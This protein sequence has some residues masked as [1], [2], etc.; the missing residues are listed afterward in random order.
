MFSAITAYIETDIINLTDCICR[1]LNLV[2]SFSSQISLSNQVYISFLD[3]Q[4]ATKRDLCKFFML[5]HLMGLII[6]A[7]FKPTDCCIA[8]LQRISGCS[9]FALAGTTKKNKLPYVR[10]AYSHLG[11]NKSDGRKTA[12]EESGYKE[13]PKGTGRRLRKGVSVF[14]CNRSNIT[15]EQGKWERNVK[16]KNICCRHKAFQYVVWWYSL[17]L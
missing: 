6:L 13:E 12:P 15:S 4:N 9:G 3:L 17:P 10:A 7:T 5:L 11:F 14:L 8:A 2:P 1:L 16:R